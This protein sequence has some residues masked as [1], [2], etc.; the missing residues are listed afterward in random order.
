[1]SSGETHWCYQCRQPI[2]LQGRHAI[3]PYC[4]GGFV[5]EINEMQGS[6]P[7]DAVSSSLED[8]HQMPDF[9]EYIN[10]FMARGG[11]EPRFGLID[12]F[13][14]FMRQRMA[15]RNPNFDVRGR[16]GSAPG[17]NWDVFSSGPYL[18]IH[19]QIPGSTLSNGNAGSGP[20]QVDYGDYFMGPGLEEL[21]GQLTMNDRRGP[22]PAS[23]SSIDAMPTIKITQTHLRSDSH[24][25]VCKERFELGS[26][27]R[28][29]PC[30]HIYHSD[31]IVPWLVEH[32]SCPVCR[33]ELPAQ[34]PSTSHGSRSWGGGN[35]SSSS[36]SNNSDG[37][38][39]RERNN[40]GRRNPLSFL[41]PFR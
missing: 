20:R 1:M 7:P 30:N 39:G 3:C 13:D 14:T 8:F 31:C 27:A 25:P 38:N 10:A 36:N 4:D 21:I 33:V 24:C 40:Q 11:R 37:S 29:M 22:P 17:Q 28:Q 9:L 35:S 32:N 6:A 12:A 41:W 23:H 16:S 5:Q 26:E 2:W 34:M 19:G 15:G 18:I